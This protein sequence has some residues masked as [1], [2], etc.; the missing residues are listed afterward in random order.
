MTE[1]EVRQLSGSTGYFY[2]YIVVIAA[3]FIMVVVYGVHYAFGIFFK[4]VLAEFGWTRALTSGAFSL[5]WFVHGFLGIILGGLNDRLGPR[6]VL[7]ICGVLF[8]LGYVLMSQVGAVW[9]LYLF[10]GVIIG[11]GLGGVYVPLTST[12]TRWFVAR[13]GIMTGIVAAGIGVGTLIAPPIA[14]WLI[15]TYD[16]RMSYSILGIVVLAVVVT[17]AQF[18]RRDPTIMGQKPYGQHEVTEQEGKTGTGSLSLREALCTGQFW[19]AFTMFFC[20]GFGMYAII[21]HIAPHA[22]D[23]GISA[24][25]AANILAAIGAASIIGKI[26]LGHVCDRS[27]SK[28][29]YIIS[30]ILLSA[31]L[32]WLVVAEEMWMLYLFV[33]VFGLAYGGLATAQPPMIA[34]L[35]GTRSHGLIYGVCANGFTFGGTI[36]PIIA[37]YVFDVTGSYQSA[38]ILCAVIGIIGLILTAVLR[39]VGSGS[40]SAR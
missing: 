26:I 13:R 11:T 37:G 29:V 28:Q 30:F 4:P 27:G 35:F 32:F 2:G 19:L 20:F 23:L 8:G 6:I 3:S 10:Y 16:W 25:S 15:T 14:N 21:L 1:K 24:T 31:S 9:Q 7:T 17:S 22:T 40:S 38:F 36:G 34:W 12:I 39:P 33:L 18:L 5:S